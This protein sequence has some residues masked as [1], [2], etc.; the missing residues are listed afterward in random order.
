[1]NE[2]LVDCL[3]EYQREQQLTKEKF[4]SLWEDVPNV[5]AGDLGG[6]VSLDSLTGGWIRFIKKCG[7]K[8][9]KLHGLR[10]TFATY[11]S[12]KGVPTKVIQKLLGHSREATTTNFYTMAYDD[13]AT[14]IIDVTNDIK[15]SQK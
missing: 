12:Y 11:L 1:M 14:S 9:V 15:K 8:K 4:G 6:T 2:L 13:Y 3:L 10:A 5:F 7:L